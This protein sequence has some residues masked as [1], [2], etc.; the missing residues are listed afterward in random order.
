FVAGALSPV[1]TNNL[2]DIP[3]F[4]NDAL[5]LDRIVPINP[6]SLYSPILFSNKQKPVAQKDI[7]NEN[8]WKGIGIRGGGAIDIR[9]FDWLK[10]RT[11]IGVDLSRGDSD[12]LTPEYFLD[13]DQFRSNAIVGKSISK[14][15]YYQVENT[16]S[17]EED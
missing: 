8:K 1:Y 15:D 5:F 2:T 14:T 16:L 7:Y 17:F 11:N 9:L 3:D 4:I 6:W 13:G 12:S 10:W